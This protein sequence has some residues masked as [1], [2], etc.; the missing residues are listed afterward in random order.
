MLNIG[1]L[2]AG[3]IGQVHARSIS[4][5]DGARLSVVADAIEDAALALATKSG[6]IVLN[7]DE[8]IASPDVDAV[9][10][11]TPTDTHYELIHAAADAKKAIFCEKPVDMSA[12]R[13]RVCIIVV[14]DAGVPFLT[15][16]N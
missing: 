15:A 9:I 12:D 2:G 10:I 8:L 1:L 16:F 13:I 3:R 6:A 11:G 4:Q 7:S 14:E 5:I